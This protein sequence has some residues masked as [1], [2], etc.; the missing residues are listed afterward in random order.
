M[1]KF[2]VG[3][4]KEGVAGLLTGLNLNNVT[5]LDRALSRAA[6]TVIQKASPPEVMV[7]EP[8]ILYDGVYDYPVNGNIFGGSLLD[9]RPQG[10]NRNPWDYVYR[11]P[12]ELFDRTK[13]YLPNGFAITFEYVNGTP[14]MRVA[15]PYPKPRAIL[16][17]MNSASGW[18]AGGGATGL[19]ADE[20]FFYTE[21]ASLRFNLSSAGTP[22]YIEKTIGSQ[23]MTAYNGVGVIFLAFE[24]SNPSNI[25]SIETQFGS[26]NANYFQQTETTPFVGPLVANQWVVYALPLAGATQVGTPDITKMDFLK[27][28][29][30][31]TDGPLTNCRFGGAWISL[32]TPAE[33]LYDTPAIFN[34]NGVLSNVITNDADEIL[35]GDAAYQIYEYECASVVAM[36][37]SGGKYTSQIEGFNQVLNGIR[38]RNGMIVQYGLYDLYQAA[39]PSQVLRVIDNYYN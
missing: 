19:V 4:L 13:A 26:D 6:A 3:N 37:M 28:I 24:T 10:M 38:A 17:N 31:Y 36:Q 8:V 25:A 18:V 21:N 12:I 29:V 9:F 1:A 27:C 15:S 30:N 33:M 35:F 23:D 16:D 32:P 7:T 2:L 20:T 22:G 5:A 11:Q 39:N 14:I 34:H